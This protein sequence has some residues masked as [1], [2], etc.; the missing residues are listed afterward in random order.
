M[1]K[2]I[3]LA[4]FVLFSISARAQNFEILNPTI[5]QGGVLI[6]HVISEQQSSRT[7][8]SFTDRFYPVNHNGYV[9]IGIDTNLLPGKYSLSLVKFE[10]ARIIDS[11]TQEV[12]VREKYFPEVIYAFKKPAAE[13]KRRASERAI[14][15]AA[16]GRADIRSDNAE[17]VYKNP[18]EDMYVTGEFG[19]RRRYLNGDVVHGGVDLRAAKGIRVE[20]I[21][22]GV[23]LLARKNFSLE[24]N[25]V[26]IDHGSGI[27]SLYLHLSRINIKEG[28]FVTKSQMIGLSGATG[29]ARGPHL[30]FMVK[31][32]GTNVDPLNFIDIMNQFFR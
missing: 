9:F 19:K 20:A 31:V 23:V 8:V 14:L 10:G 6:I 3:F 25:L 7:V 4:W 1:K 18:L 2:I 13:S 29:D 24:G 21:N 11:S 26:V 28:D 22:S 30:H 32:N 17:G 16:Y 15:A 27:F 5:E 12:E